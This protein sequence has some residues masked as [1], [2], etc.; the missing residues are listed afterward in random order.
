[1]YDREWARAVARARGLN[2][3]EEEAERLA[4]AVG[5]ILER[6][7]EIA[8]ELTA[9]DDMYEFRRLLAQE[10]LRG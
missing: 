9:D 7:Q 1:M 5:P 6:F 2:V 3:D 8:R 10:G 4:A